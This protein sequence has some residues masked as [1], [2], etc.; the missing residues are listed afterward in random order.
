M[1]A[2]LGAYLTDVYR[3][4]GYAA[5]VGYSLVMEGITGAELVGRLMDRLRQ[6]PPD[7]VA[8]RALRRASDF[9]D[10][11][12]LRSDPFRNRPQLA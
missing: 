5:N 2:T 10:D 7:S 8:G 9:W 12:A 4:Y 1:A 11:T 3:R 6:H